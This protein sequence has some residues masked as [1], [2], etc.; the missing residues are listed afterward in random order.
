MYF[1]GDEFY[2]ETTIDRGDEPRDDGQLVATLACTDVMDLDIDYPEL[3]EDA[4]P[5][6]PGRVQAPRPIPNS[7]TRRVA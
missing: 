2:G 1:P 5:I 4:D 3:A 6:L 7:P